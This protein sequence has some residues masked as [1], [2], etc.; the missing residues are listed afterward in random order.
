MPNRCYKK[1]ILK[2]RLI[3]KYMLWRVD[4]LRSHSFY[5]IKLILKQWTW[6][7]IKFV[8]KIYLFKFIYVLF[9]NKEHFI[10]IRILCIIDKKFVGY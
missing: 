3:K 4:S 6:I 1:H 10:I 2:L 8:I 7:N 5:I 9:I